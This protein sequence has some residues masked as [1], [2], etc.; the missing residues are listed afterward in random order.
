LAQVIAGFSLSDME[1]KRRKKTKWADTLGYKLM[2]KCT[3]EEWRAYLIEYK[4]TTKRGL[5]DKEK[6]AI[7]K[8]LFRR[9]LDYHATDDLAE[10]PFE[11]AQ[12]RDFY[13]NRLWE[14]ADETGE[15]GLSPGQ[16]RAAHTPPGG[17]PRQNGKRKHRSS[18]SGRRSSVSHNELTNAVAELRN[19]KAALERALASANE[20]FAQLEEEKQRDTQQHIVVNQL[21]AQLDAKD[22]E[23]RQILVVTRMLRRNVEKNAKAEVAQLK[24]ELNGNKQLLLS[25]QDKALDLQASVETA[26]QDARHHRRMKLD[27]LSKMVLLTRALCAPEYGPEQRTASV[28]AYFQQLRADE[29]VRATLEPHMDTNTMF[30]S[31][32]R[33]A[34][35]VFT[36]ET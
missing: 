3:A 25:L 19:E 26:Q 35:G 24:N 16:A 4:A 23:L 21:I 20:K 7:R 8:P 14:V 6:S 13:H 36:Y 30:A 33:R 10:Y 2:Q 22:F 32:L 18:E 9:F 29:D 27:V 17:F 28:Y 34:M 11:Y 15:A 12:M 1:A 31:L 5:T